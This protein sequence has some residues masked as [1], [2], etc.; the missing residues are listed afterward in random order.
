M[1]YA[2]NAV[3]TLYLK[4]YKLLFLQNPIHNVSYVLSFIHAYVILISMV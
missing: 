2:V 4:Y 3:Y 1:L